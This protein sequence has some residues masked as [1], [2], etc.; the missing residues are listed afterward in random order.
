[1]RT[2]TSKVSML[3]LLTGVVCAA[4]CTGK[5]GSAAGGVGRA[6]DGPGTGVGGA[7]NAVASGTG[8]T[9]N[10]GTTGVGN[11]P[12]TQAACASAAPDTAPSV[13]R[14]LSNLE[15]KLT[16]QDLFR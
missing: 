8:G 2:G 4:A 1:M 14:R 7:G 5:V 12:G 13:L 11:G 9:G 3:A 16:L 10:V 6:G 15:Y